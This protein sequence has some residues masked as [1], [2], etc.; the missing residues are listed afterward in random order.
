[1]SDGGNAVVELSTVA[2]LR[3]TAAERSVLG[4]FITRAI[5]PT[6]PPATTAPGP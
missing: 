3:A 1:M 5:R 2:T 4:A 6:G